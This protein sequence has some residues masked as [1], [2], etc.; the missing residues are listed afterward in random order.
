M[1]TIEQVVDKLIQL[2][3]CPEAIGYVREFDD[4]Q[5]CW[6]RCE[7]VTWMAWLL[8]KLRSPS[9][10]Y[11][12]T[13]LLSHEHTCNVHSIRQAYPQAPSFIKKGE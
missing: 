4:W 13:G 12:I 9:E 10:Y 1:P 6:D 8:C 11:D 3:V 5:Q 2:R 7:R